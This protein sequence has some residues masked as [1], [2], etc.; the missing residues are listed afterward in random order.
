MW[1][2]AAWSGGGNPAP[3]RG[4]ETR[5]S[6]WSFSTQDILWFYEKPGFQQETYL[7]I[8]MNY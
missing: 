5:W 1:L 6:L 3:G 4:V 8:N 2:W 7:A